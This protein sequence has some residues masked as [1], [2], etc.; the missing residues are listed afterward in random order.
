MNAGDNVLFTGDN[1]KFADPA[2][3]AA[4]SFEVDFGAAIAGLG[5]QIQSNAYSAFNAT[6]SVYNGLTLLGTFN[7]SGTSS[8]AADGSAPFLGARSDAVDITRAI[9]SISTGDTELDAFGLGVNR[10]LVTDVPFRQDATVPE[11][12]TLTLMGI[13][14]A[15]FIRNRRRQKA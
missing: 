12:G 1:A 2:Y 4:T 14:A 7:V 9:F 6:L 8:S 11:P 13:G 5:L 15:A 3:T 10:L